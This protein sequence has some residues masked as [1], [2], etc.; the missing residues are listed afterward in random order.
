ME[1]IKEVICMFC[2]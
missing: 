1:H 2:E